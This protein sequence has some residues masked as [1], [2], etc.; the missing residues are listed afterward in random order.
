VGTDKQP[1]LVYRHVLEKIPLFEVCLRIPCKEAGMGVIHLRE[2]SPEVFEKVLE[3]ALSGRIN[4][5]KPEEAEGDEYGQDQKDY[6]IAL[7]EL[8]GL[9]DFLQMEPL[10]NGIIDV[11]LDH[12]RAWVD[13]FDVFLHLEAEGLEDSCFMELALACRA[14]H[15]HRYDETHSIN[16][17]WLKEYAYEDSDR[18]KRLISALVGPGLEFGGTQ[19]GCRWHK[20]DLTPKCKPNSFI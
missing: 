17:K 14:T 4:I 3:Y 10:A 12:C 13:S 7:V 5:E 15:L 20:H 6:A 19:S 11:Y 16:D 1:F 9:A 2:A 8:Y 18:M